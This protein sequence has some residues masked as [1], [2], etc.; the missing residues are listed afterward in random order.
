MA[1]SANAKMTAKVLMVA[2]SRPI[3]ARSVKH[4]G[5]KRKFHF[6]MPGHDSRSAAAGVR[7]GMI[8]R[9]R[10]ALAQGWTVACSSHNRAIMS[11]DQERRHA[12]ECD[13]NPN[14]KASVPKESVDHECDS[15]L[16]VLG[17]LH[18]LSQLYSAGIVVVSGCGSHLVAASGCVPLTGWCDR[19]TKNIDSAT[20][21]P[22]INMEIQCSIAIS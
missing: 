11:I 21:A 1:I 14:R 12:A 22:A 19:K 9:M 8:G 3:E 18:G 15:S 5:E 17:R 6:G 13:Q 2:L 20:I 7:V 10:G 4:R 16:K